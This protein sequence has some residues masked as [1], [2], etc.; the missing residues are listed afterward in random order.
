MITCDRHTQT[1]FNGSFKDITTEV[2]LVVHN[3]RKFCI[4]NVGEEEA[5]KIMQRLFNISQMSME[6]IR[7]EVSARRFADCIIKNRPNL[8][9]E[10]CEKIEKDIVRGFKEIVSGN[11]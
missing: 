10:E 7:M 8:T 5:A 11:E 1:E 4:E 2:G 3:F 9:R 6:D